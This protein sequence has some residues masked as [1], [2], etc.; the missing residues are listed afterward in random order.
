MVR[1]RSIFPDAPSPSDTVLMRWEESPVAMGAYT[2][3]R[4]SS[5]PRDVQRFAQPV[6]QVLYSALLNPPFSS[7]TLTRMT[8]LVD[9]PIWW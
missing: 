2:F 7:S 4:T 5:T 6:E 9:C 3:L 1:L 8:L